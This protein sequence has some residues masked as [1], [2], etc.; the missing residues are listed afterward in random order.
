MNKSHILYKN[1]KY[2]I[3][4][5]GRRK[6]YDVIIIG[7][8]PAGLSAAVY[9]GRAMLKV[10]VLEK[11]AFSGGQIVYTEQVDNYLGLKGLSGLEL[12]RRFRTHAEDMQVPF[13]EGSAEELTKTLDGF[14]IKL[15]DGTVLETK[16][17]IVASGA[18]YRR[19][20]IQGEEQLIGK[21]VSYCATCDGAFFRQKEVAVV[22]GGDVALSDALYL[23]KLCKKVYLIH[24][25]KEFRAAMQ[26]QEQVKNTENIEF[27]P[28]YEV[29]RIL[30]EGHVRTVELQNN[31]TRERKELSVAGIFVA[32]GMEPETA[33]LNG[34]AAVDA[35]G[36]L[37]A[38][39]DCVTDV[40]GLFAAGD[41]RSKAVRQVVTA[42][43]DGA[44]AVKSAEEYL[45]EKGS[46]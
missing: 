33:Y 4:G 25:R 19:L 9:G 43:A 20:G 13:L 5:N 41:V 2:R 23:S 36:Y 8:G 3:F 37:L 45:R 44:A 10:L 30:G 28:H 18:K 17:I 34:M 32:V 35:G 22:G 42:V 7:S 26:L 6:M 14:R 27:L 21:G 16:T 46:L 1:K 38:G 39:E 40:P 12:A 11:A 24:R 15:L 29:Q 31:Q